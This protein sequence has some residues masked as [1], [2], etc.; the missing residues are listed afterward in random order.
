MVRF[1]ILC[2]AAAAA[3]SC[4]G[5]STAPT[6]EENRELDRASEMLDRAPGRLNQADS[7]NLVLSNETGEDR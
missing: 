1:L 7:S 4:G 2:A 6:P 5:S 3:S